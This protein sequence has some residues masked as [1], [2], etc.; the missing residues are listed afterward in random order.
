MISQMDLTDIY[1][2]FYSIALE[3]TFFSAVHG[4]FF[5]T[6]HILGHKASLNKHKKTE[7]TSCS[8]SD[9]NGIKL[10]INSMRNYRN[11]TN[12]WR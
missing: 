11:Y 12:T 1:R 5:K 3:Y 8:L 7:L 9:H 2:I 6:N 4:T 10:E